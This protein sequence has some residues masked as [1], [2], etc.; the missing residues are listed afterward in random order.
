MRARARAFLFSLPLLVAATP[1]HA[2]TTPEATAVAQEPD[3][4]QELLAEKTKLN[5]IAIGPTLFSLLPTGAD[6]AAQQRPGVLIDLSA[7]RRFDRHFGF[8]LR[9]AWG[10]SEFRRVDTFGKQAYKIGRWTTHA[11]RDVWGWA[12]DADDGTAPLRVT[13]ALFAS[14]FLWMPYLAAAATYAAA[15]FSPTT[16]VELDALATFD[17]DNGGRD[18]FAPYLKAGLGFVAMLHP[19]TDKLLGGAGPSAAVG[20][21][22]YSFDLSL[23]STFLPRYLHGETSGEKS[24]VLLSGFTLGYVF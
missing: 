7:Q 22:I 17:F 19:R 10:L 6:T 8:G 20:A 23:K 5:T 1:L 13:G 15:L 9:L 12:T 16:Y 2:Q 3:A 14:V 18:A 11:Y 4:Q 21:R 24:H